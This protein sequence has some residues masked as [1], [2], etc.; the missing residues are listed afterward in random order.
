MTSKPPS[1]RGP[2]SPSADL[3]IPPPPDSR[4]PPSTRGPLSVRA[5]SAEPSIPA[6]PDSRNPTSTRNPL[7]VRGPLSVRAPSSP[8]I[9][10]PPPPDSRSSFARDGAPPSVRVPPGERLCLSH[11]LPPGQVFASREPTEVTTIVGSCAAVCLWDADL[12]VGGVNHYL[13]PRKPYGLQPSGR[14]ADSAFKLLLDALTGF[15]C[16]A[17]SLRAWLVG[18][19]CLIE[20]FR[21]RGEHLGEQ[22]VK[23]GTRLLEHARIQ[24]IGQDTGGDRGRKVIFRTDRGTALVQPL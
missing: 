14:Y 22:N 2:L 17:D 24:V 11:Y 12:N 18:G 1:S 7:S 10:A 16:R 13:L 15:G 20:A 21:V 4:N 3:R 5:P 6:P 8:D 23:I 19:A 9:R